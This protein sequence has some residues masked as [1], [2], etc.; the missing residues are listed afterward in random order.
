[1]NSSVSALLAPKLDLLVQRCVRFR[2][3]LLSPSH[4]AW[5]RLRPGTRGDAN[6]EMAVAVAVPERQEFCRA[7]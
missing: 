5:L 1:M 7:P 3:N 2:A 4:T 6:A